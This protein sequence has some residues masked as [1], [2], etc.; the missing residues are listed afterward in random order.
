M[1]G[2]NGTYGTVGGSTASSDAMLGDDLISRFSTGDEIRGM[3]KPRREER[4]ES[5]AAE[6]ALGLP[7]DLSF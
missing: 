7:P 3:V 5:L 4:K 2:T 1:V 6:D